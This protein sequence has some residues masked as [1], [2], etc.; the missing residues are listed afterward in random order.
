[1]PLWSKAVPEIDILEWWPSH[2][3]VVAD[4]LGNTVV[5]TTGYSKPIDS[6]DSDGNHRWSKV[7]G[8]GTFSLTDVA[9]NSSGLVAISGTTRDGIDLGGGWLD[10][11]EGG[12]YHTVV[13]LFD[14]AG[15]HIWSQVFSGG[16]D[17]ITTG[18]DVSLD[19]DGNMTLRGTFN[20]TV[21]FGDV[22]LRAP[23]DG[24]ATPYFFAKLDPTGRPL[25]A[26][27][28]FWRAAAIDMTT[29]A[30]GNIA[31]FG[32]LIGRANFG[33][34][35]RVTS[36]TPRTCDEMFV[37]KYDADGAYV[38]DRTFRA[39]QWEVSGIA[40]D[41]SGNI[42]LTGTFWGDLDLGAVRLQSRGGPVHI[43]QGDDPGPFPAP[44]GDIF[45]MKLA[46]EGDLLWARSFGDD[47]SQA[48]TSIAMTEGGELALTGNMAGR[49]EIGADTVDCAIPHA[50]VTKLD[51]AGDPLWVAHSCASLFDDSRVGAFAH[52]RTGTSVTT[53]GAGNVIATGPFAGTIDF[54]AGPLT[55]PDADE[56]LHGFLVK[57]PP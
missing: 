16:P 15:E 8:P 35:E 28:Y 33:G 51:P 4:G 41:G 13:G 37:V 53:D 18:S 47:K 6:F 22:V 38:W 54:G 21:T 3:V 2:P 50:F 46:P 11:P 7:F 12:D 40:M 44:G 17:T 57:F 27:S 45:V 14:A 10:V 42:A 49:L 56:P 20:S 43:S 48:A 24:D 1:M 26:K 29:D 36:C 55:Q 30:S 31:M 25:W 19:A 9:V 5:Y 32:L 39:E 34:G 52:S 23:E